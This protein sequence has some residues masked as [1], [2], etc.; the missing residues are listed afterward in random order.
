MAAT[1]T[2]PRTRRRVTDTDGGPT[3]RPA[4]DAF[5]DTPKIKG[6]PN[7]LRTYT[8][9]LDRLA[10][11]LDANRALADVEDSEIGDALGGL[12][13]EREAGDVEPQP[14]RGRLLAHLV[15]RQ[16]ALGRAGAA[17]LG[18]AA[19]GEPR[20]HQGRLALPDRPAVPAPGRAAAGEDAVADALRVRQQGLRRARTEHRGPGPANKQARITAKG[21]DAMWI[22]WGTD[23]AR[24][25][26]RLIASRERG[27]LFLSQHR[28][29]PHR[30]ATTDPRDICPETGRARLGYDRARVL[31]ARYGDGLRLHQLRHSAATHLGEANVSA[32]VIMAKTGHKSLRQCSATSD[33]AWPPSTRPPR[34][35]LCPADALIA[36]SL[37]FLSDDSG[38]GAITIGASTCAPHL[39]TPPITR[40]IEH[41]ADAIP[42]PL[43][44]H[45]P[46]SI[47]AA[48]TTGT[49][50]RRRAAHRSD[51]TSA[52]VPPVEDRLGKA[53]DKL[54]YETAEQ[55]HQHRLHRRSRH[56]TYL[57]ERGCCT[58]GDA[59][60][61]PR[62]RRGRSNPTPWGRAIVRRW[63]STRS[64]P[65]R[66]AVAH[67]PALTTGRPARTRPVRGRGSTETRRPT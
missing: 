51:T 11:R 26:P 61:L 7:T 48:Q 58:A 24:L 10:D 67:G 1:V 43:Y 62:P 23:T 35:S 49:R 18:G 34:R 5:L 31:L 65:R 16:A 59:C 25:L 44:G 55:S 14:R 30:K 29:G 19:P 54:R 33:P 12:W 66:Y 42:R 50:H 4:I 9:V 8:G 28:P 22:T 13:G 47:P 20:R 46:R 21:G 40:T 63:R 3:A 6:N 27:P 2:K 45:H 56:D 37:H 39:A 64:R 41:P 53:V 32:N 57:R 17:G 38:F 15:R 36:G 52:S 60:S